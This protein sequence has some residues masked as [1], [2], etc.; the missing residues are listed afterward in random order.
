VQ[1]PPW[2]QAGSRAFPAPAAFYRMHWATPTFYMN[3]ALTSNSLIKR[4]SQQ[5]IQ[6][7]LLAG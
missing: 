6:V 4:M 2:I 5:Y 3:I 7:S 1:Q